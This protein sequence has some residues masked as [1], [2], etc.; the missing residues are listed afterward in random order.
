MVRLLLK[1]GADVEC[2][3]NN[4]RT[5]W[6]A[7][8]QCKSPG[9]LQILL[10]AGANPST[11][12]QQGVSELYTAAKD[13]NIEL[14]KYILKSGTNPSIQTQYGWAPLHWAASYGHIDCVRLLLESGADPNSISDQRVTPLDLATQADQSKVLVLLH[15]VGARSYRDTEVTAEHNFNEAEKD[16]EWDSISSPDRDTTPVVSLEAEKPHL[17]YDKPLARTLSK[18]LLL[19]DLCFRVVPLAPQTISMKFL[20]SSKLHPPQ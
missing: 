2:K 3:D 20:I 18:S 14:V 5:P 1:S 10:D 9:I 16:A 4:H 11:C 15:K 17:V 7:N 8:L 12:G 19:G 13:G 6:S